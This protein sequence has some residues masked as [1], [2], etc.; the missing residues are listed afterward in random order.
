VA[1]LA[2]AVL[3]LT[4]G[5]CTVHQP[6]TVLVPF[7]LEGAHGTLDCS[8]C[9]TDGFDQELPRSCLGC[10]QED[11]PGLHWEDDCGDCHGQEVWDD[12]TYPHEEWPLDGAHLLVACEDCHEEPWEAETSCLACHGD[13]APAG[14]LVNECIFCHG[15]EA[16]QPPTFQHASFPLDGAHAGL[17]CT[18]CHVGGEMH[19]PHQCQDCHSADRPLNH[20]PGDCGQC[21][22]ATEWD[23]VTFDHGFFPLQGGHDRDCADCHANGYTDVPTDCED[24]HSPP[25]HHFPSNCEWCH[26]IYGWEH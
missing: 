22:R 7:D 12:L 8:A 5:D 15:T 13:D 24:C 6:D 9:H 21:H 23:D 2:A 14:H 19:P 17:G 16:W 10:H 1:L 18:D 26:D 3:V 4:A 20:P 11:R 25:D